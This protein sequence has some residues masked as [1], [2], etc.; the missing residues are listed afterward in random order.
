MKLRDLI[1]YNIPNS[2]I[3][4][5]QKRQGDYLL[6]LQEKAVKNGLLDKEA[7]NL[8]IS[9]PTS[10]GKSFCGE[11]AAIA[12]LVE[13]K[14]AVM[15]LPL[16]SIAE[17]KYQYYRNCYRKIGLKVIIATG[18]HPENDTN[19]ELGNFDLALAIYEKFNRLLTVNLD[20]LAQIGLVIV[21]ELQMLGQPRRGPE[22][23]SGLTKL[24]ASPYNPRL[25]ALSAV[26]D[27][28]DRIASWLNAR[29]VAETVRPVD[30]YHGVASGGSFHFRSFNSGQEGCEDIALND[31]NPEEG[32]S[33]LIEFIKSDD[34]QKLIF[35]KSRR[36]T[37]EAA[38]SL[39]AVSNWGEAKKTLEAL[40]GEEH[41]FLIRALRQ[42]LS[43]G[44][45][46]HNADLTG[47]QRQAVENGYRRGE[48]KV[49]FSTTT[50]AMGVN[51]PAETV[52]LETMKYTSAD[53]G[54]RP[55]LVPITRAEFQNIA[56][57]AGRFGVSKSPGRAI[58][59]A[60]SEFE[61]EVLWS[62][63]VDSQE[64]EELKS[65]LGE[66]TV[67]NI[68]LDLAATGFGG[69]DFEK[70]INSSLYHHQDKTFPVES[71]DSAI[72][73]LTQWRLLDDRIHPTPLGEAVAESGL[74]VASC[75]Q[76]V[77]SI[78]RRIPQDITGW[79]LLALSGSD[80]EI[81]QAGLNGA[82]FQNR[83][84]EK[85]FYQEYPEHIAD[86][87]AYTN[88]GSDGASLDFRAMSI[89]KAALLLGQ[90]ADG[91]TVEKLEQRYQLHHGQ[92]TNLAETASWLIGALGRILHTR[93]RN[94]RYAADLDDISFRVQ[95][96]IPP[97]MREI[98]F[99]ARDYLNRIDFIRL[100]EKDITT[101]DK[102]RQLTADDLRGI[103]E[104]EKRRQKFIETISK[105][106]KEDSMELQVQNYPDRRKTSQKTRLNT[107]TGLTPSMLELD[108]HY[109]RERYL[110]KIDGRPVRLTGKSFKYLAK[111]VFA[112][113][114]GNDGWIYKDDIEAGFNQA[115][116]LYRLKQ[117][118]RS[119]G[120][121]WQIFENNRLGYY[122]LALGPDKV[123]VDYENLRRHHDF[124]V[125]QLVEEGDL[126]KT[127]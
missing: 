73:H 39:A 21:D 108:G 32:N 63:Y 82:E 118:F 94:S 30:L 64:R 107:R 34:S 24:L 122:R 117:E 47:R 43:H 31:D 7:G 72:V 1:K 42:T 110:V 88:S 123:R 96:G 74:D 61:R 50:L 3:E 121:D 26:L 106:N 79:L 51:L 48:I 12:S 104:P 17:E 95:F 28:P 62:N 75:R 113:L 52:L 125:R 93:D 127:G 37:I 9:A 99:F 54:G 102:L 100:A 44:V 5:W 2:I 49:I 71:I 115:R 41:S 57:R 65:C 85:L 14:K 56:G 70:A 59:R 78:D 91:I 87:A 116:Y 101:I 29:T 6:P 111:L 76:Y 46:F 35:L 92:I 98:F 19:F 20:I 90:W 112:R 55:A 109:E 67:E 69:G 4:A 119:G 16:K 68:I 15:L 89:L 77:T 66:C 58:A 105:L 80:F 10:S 120:V 23:E 124:E 60:Q 22:L 38:F 27:Q 40:E 45:A 126:R 8:I 53:F 13:R 81:S 11:L 86:L 33:G 97:K 36:D 103:V 84:Y 18:D 25:L 114:S 83:I